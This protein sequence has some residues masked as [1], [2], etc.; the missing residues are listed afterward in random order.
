MSREREL[1]LFRNSMKQKKN[2]SKTVL[3]HIVYQQF[4][5]VFEMWFDFVLRIKMKMCDEYRVLSLPL[6]L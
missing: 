3:F 1:L 2:F 5:R 4:A 6:K